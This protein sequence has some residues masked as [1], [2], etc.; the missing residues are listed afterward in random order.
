MKK[1]S[2]KFSLLTVVCMGLVL[3]ACKKDEA[4]QVSELVKILKTQNPLED[5]LKALKQAEN[6]E[7]QLLKIAEDRRKLMDGGL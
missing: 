1:L 3:T 5:Q 7:A 2:K 6:L 4:P